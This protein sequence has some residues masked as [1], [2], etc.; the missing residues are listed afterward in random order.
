MTSS[1]SRRRRWCRRRIHGERMV[2]AGH[3]R[4]GPTPM[5]APMYRMSSVERCSRGY[6]HPT[7]DVEMSR[8]H[9]GQPRRHAAA[10]R[11]SRARDAQSHGLAHA[12]AGAS[13]AAPS[14]CSGSRCPASSRRACPRTSS[15]CGVPELSSTSARS[16][17]ASSARRPQTVAWR[18]ITG[19]N[20][21]T[22]TAY[23]LAQASELVG[24]RSSY[25]G[26][27]GFGRAF[28]LARRRTDDTRRDQRAP[29]HRAAARRSRGDAG[30][31]GLVARARSSVASTACASTR[32]SS[33]T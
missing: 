12:A 32:P 14:P 22:T 28:E 19:T 27:L 5:R 23:L 13:N 1:A 11:S 20:G 9:A 4:H 3:E 26:T 10:P 21:K 15:V 24:R 29:P 17:I 8:P 16:P 18:G 2:S 33:R 25:L 7:R 6:A 31:R 30:D